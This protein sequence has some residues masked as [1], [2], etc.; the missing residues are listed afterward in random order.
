M[1]LVLSSYGLSIGYYATGMNRLKPET[2]GKT[3]L[4]RLEESQETEPSRGRNRQPHYSRI[5][6]ELAHDRVVLYAAAYAGLSA[7]NS[8]YLHL[9]L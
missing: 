4:S 9:A 5:L 6:G 8:N 2:E 1:V 3:A 7:F